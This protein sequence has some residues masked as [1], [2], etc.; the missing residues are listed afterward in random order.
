M[1][2]TASKMGNCKLCGYPA[3][4]QESHVVPKFV[5]KSMKG[6]GAVEDPK[7][8]KARGGEFSK[9][10][11]DLPKQFWLCR[12]CE[13][14]LSNSEKHFAEIVYQPLWSRCVQAGEVNNDHVHRFLV[15]MAW[16]AWNWYDEQE[17]NIYDGVLNYER[18]REA[19][20]TWRMY[21]LGKRDDVGQF[22]QHMLIQSA[23][24]VHS[25]GC[26]VDLD[27]YYWSRSNGLDILDDGGPQKKVL[28]VYAKIPKIAMFGVVEQQ[29]SG[30]WRGT[31][32]EP[33]LGDTWTGQQAVVPDA[34]LQ[35]FE[36]QRVKMKRVFQDVPET[37][38]DRVSQRMDRLI[39][40][41]RDDYLKR[42]A[43]RS[44]VMDDMVE[45]P[46]ESIVSCAIS[47]LADHTDAR[48]RKMGE[49]FGHLTEREMRSLHKEVNRA[50]LRCKTLN[51]EERFSVLADGKKDT[52]KPGRVILVGVEVFPTRELAEQKSLL[53]LK[54]GLN[55]EDVTVAMGAEILEV[56]VALSQRGTRR[57]SQPS[58]Y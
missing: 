13:E 12:G 31:L 8:Y 55:T 43:V 15:S 21:L 14:L 9:L 30:H 27:G 50:G 26:A 51:V 48:A 38:R 28:M 19:E 54:F 20:E 49:L 32:V 17:D 47:R 18:L 6:T 10:E 44:L 5:R 4:L 42:D 3:M 40:T 11:Q 1:A 35:Y 24:S 57:L 46:E 36:N 53:P 39:E 23:P 33:G 58:H 16:R 22:E 7:Y 25:A 34:L 56:P 37:V 45:L 52:S 41:E 29:N 2:T